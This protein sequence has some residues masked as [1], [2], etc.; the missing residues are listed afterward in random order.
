MQMAPAPDVFSCAV[1]RIRAARNAMR[2]AYW[3]LQGAR[4]KRRE[5]RE[6]R[7]KTGRFLALSNSTSN[8]I[9]ERKFDR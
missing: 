1:A 4:I 9:G 8:P 3:S 2:E 7:R 5:A 6:L